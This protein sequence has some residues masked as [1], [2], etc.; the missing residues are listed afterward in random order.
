MIDA[1][2]QMPSAI[3]R[4]LVV[5]AKLILENNGEAFNMSRYLSDLDQDE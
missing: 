5:L 4:S 3:I 2:L 1:I